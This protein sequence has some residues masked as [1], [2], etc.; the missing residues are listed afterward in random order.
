[1]N[2][3]VVESVAVR[4]ARDDRHD[5]LL[6]R[7]CGGVRGDRPRPAFRRRLAAA[8]AVDR[9]HLERVRAP[10]EARAPPRVTPHGAQAPPSQRHSD[11]DGSEV[12]QANLARRAV[13]DGNPVSVVS[14]SATSVRQ[15]AAGAPSPSSTQPSGPTDRTVTRWMPSRSPRSSHPP[16]RRRRAGTRS[17][18][19]R[20]SIAA[21]GSTSRVCTRPAGARVERGRARV[22]P[23]AEAPRHRP[24]LSPGRDARPRSRARRQR[25]RAEARRIVER[26]SVRPRR[27]PRTAAAGRAGGAAARP[28]GL[29]TLEPDDDPG[30]RRRIGDHQRTAQVVEQRRRRRDRDRRADRTARAVEALRPDRERSQHRAT[31]AP[32]TP[33]GTRRSTARRR[34]RASGRPRRCRAR[35]RRSG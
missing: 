16:R 27:A 26:T 20:A 31:R 28:P 7:A 6:G 8:E 22:G 19:R 4:R 23:L 5:R 9:P 34:A 11:V 17:P 25:G 2:V 1:M 24:L 13:V 10:V 18:R 30:L 15:R 33:R 32:P 14:G 12:V 21:A 35:C 3:A 29:A